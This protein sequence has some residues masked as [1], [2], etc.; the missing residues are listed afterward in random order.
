MNRLHIKRTEYTPL[1]DF[2]RETLRLVLAGDSYPE[3]TFEF[4]APV[5]GYIEDLLRSDIKGTIQFQF[6]LNYYNSSTSKI[7]F[8]L[9]DLLDEARTRGKAVHIDWLYDERNEVM[10]EAGAEFIQEFPN[11]QLRLST[12]EKDDP[13][14]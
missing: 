5:L 4:Y 11:L 13:A 14:S 3:N 8:D 9:F 10:R 6:R 7:L 1:V 2:N 12:F